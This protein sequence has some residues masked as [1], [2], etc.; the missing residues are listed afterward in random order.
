MEVTRQPPLQKVATDVSSF[1]NSMHD[2]Q[3]GGL[4]KPL[5]LKLLVLGLFGVNASALAQETPATPPP[6]TT[7]AAGTL[8][9]PSATE[10]PAPA[11]ATAPAVPPKVVYE[12]L[13]IVVDGK[14][15]YAG[16]I[17]LSIEPDGRAAK[18]VSVNALAKEKDKKI[19]EQLHREVS[20]ALGAEYKVK[21]SGTDIRISKATKAAPPVGVVVT[22][23]QLPGVSVRVERD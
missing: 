17:A 9:A 5:I 19:A 1:P 3:E 15:E 10:A 22:T 20:I 4:M 6:A 2:R 11:P 12:K 13:R 23:L 18:A 7:D 8:P 16:T 21:L 14:A